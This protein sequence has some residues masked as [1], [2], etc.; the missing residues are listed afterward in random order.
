MAAYQSAHW[1]YAKL[2][3][4]KD[5]KP[6]QWMEKKESPMKKPL[7]IMNIPDVRRMLLFAKS[8]CRSSLS[9]SYW[10]PNIMILYNLPRTL[11]VKEKMVY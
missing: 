2:N 6:F 4:P 9:L 3:G 8:D 7:L 5:E 10:P 1:E 11:E